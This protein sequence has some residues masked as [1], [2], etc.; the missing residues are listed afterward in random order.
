MAKGVLI[1]HSDIVEGGD[2]AEFNRWYSEV[3]AP[4]ILDRGA[5]VSFERYAA[6]DIPLADGIPQI[7]GYVCVYQI[8][9]ET[10]DDVE[11]IQQRLRDTKHMSR[12]MSD[13]MDLR[14]V[15]ADFFVPIK[16]GSSS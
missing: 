11:A 6:T 13:E 8:D 5:A 9:A 1:V 16:G 14:S 4:E 7:G 15:R 3:H 10:V 2:E 12:G